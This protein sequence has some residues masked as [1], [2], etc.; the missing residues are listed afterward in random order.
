MIQFGDDKNDELKNV[1][2][3][4]LEIGSLTLAIWKVPVY[5]NLDIY[6]GKHC[7]SISWKYFYLGISKQ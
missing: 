2:L 4:R 1:N 6:N 7:F 3:F 5:G